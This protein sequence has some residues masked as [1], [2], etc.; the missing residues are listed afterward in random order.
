[1]AFKGFSSPWHLDANRNTEFNDECGWDSCYSNVLRTS[2]VWIL[3]L[4]KMVA[5][6]KCLRYRCASR[7]MMINYVDDRDNRNHLYEEC[8]DYFVPSNIFNLSRNEGRKLFI[9]QSRKKK[10]T[11]Y[12]TKLVHLKYIRLFGM[13]SKMSGGENTLF[14]SANTVM[15][16]IP[17]WRP[18]FEISL[19]F[20]LNGTTCFHCNSLIEKQI[21]RD[22]NLH[23]TFRISIPIPID[24]CEDTDF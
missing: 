20:F 1:M 15:G 23:V 4:R 12:F 14:E 24:C 2:A 3:R 13:I 5:A 10:Y 8:S 21:Q 9:F 7:L 16:R 11:G 6:S 18:F 19:Y 17:F 22:A